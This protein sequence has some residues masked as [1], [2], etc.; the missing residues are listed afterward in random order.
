MHKDSQKKA[1]RGRPPLIGDEEARGI[2]IDC[3]TYTISSGKPNVELWGI[4]GKSL[5]LAVA[6]AQ[7]EIDIQWYEGDE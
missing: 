2:A 3:L 4:Y 5:T 6:Q 1:V 7:R